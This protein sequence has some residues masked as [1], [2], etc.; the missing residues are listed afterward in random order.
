MK[1]LNRYVSAFDGSL[2]E[3]PEILKPIRMHVPVN[4]CLGMIDNLV[5]VLVK[6][7]IRLQRI[8]VEFGT[9]SDTLPEHNSLSHR[10]TSP[11]HFLAS[12]GVH[13]P[14]FAADESLVS[15]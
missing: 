3:A 14:R 6:P 9:W 2:Q 1:W 5:R 8:S 4:I 15:F 13:I 11:N 12:S 7:V 10:A